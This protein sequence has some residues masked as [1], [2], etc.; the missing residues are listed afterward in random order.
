M[1]VPPENSMRAFVLVKVATGHEVEAMKALR[2]I[3]NVGDVHFLFGEFDY[4]LSVD[5]TSWE[6]LSRLLSQRVRRIPGVEQTVT[7]LEAPI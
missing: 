6:G 5:S 1:H 3:P 7:L 4:I 2:A